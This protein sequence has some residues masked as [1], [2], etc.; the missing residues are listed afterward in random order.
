MPSSVAVAAVTFD[1]P[2]ELAVLLNAINSQTAP[3][4][5][6]CLV[7]SGKTP[8][9]E[10]AG[11]HPNVDYVRSEANLG[12]A[13]GFALAALK[14]V[15]SGARWIWMMDDDAEPTDPECLATLLREAEARDLEAVVPLVVAPGQPDRLSYL[16]V[17]AN[18][19][20]PETTST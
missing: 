15:A 12:G 1:R 6:I 3:V 8:A 5:S 2:G 14:A 19:G 11:L 13:G 20:C 9:R 10:A 7:D 17:E 16:S 18:S 4:K